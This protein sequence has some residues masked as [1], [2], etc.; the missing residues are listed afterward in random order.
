MLRGRLVMIGVGIVM[1]ASA[2][3]AAAATI[4]VNTTNDDQQQGDGRCSLRKAIAEVNSP[5]IS[6]TDCAPAAF[7]ANTIVLGGGS[8]LLGFSGASLNVASTADLR[9]LGVGEGSTF[10]D[11]RLLSNRAFTIAPGATVLLRNLTVANGHAPGGSSAAPGSGGAGQAG[12]NGGA[13]LNQGTLTV[14]NS[15]VTGSQGGTG[16]AGGSGPSPSSS[17]GGSGGAGGPGGS[18]GGIYNT[19]T[20]TLIGSTIADDDAGS[21]GAGGQGGQGTNGGVGGNGGAA[22]DGGGV[23]NA[24]G[25]LTVIDST[26]RSNGAG[27]GGAGGN[28]GSG[29]SGS[30]GAGGAGAGGAG[31]GGLATDGGALSVTNSTFASDTAGS[32]GAGGNGGAGSTTGGPGGAGGGAGS[33]GAVSASSPSSATLLQVTAAANDPGTPGAGGSAGTGASA[34]ASGGAGSGGAVFD[35]GSG[36]TLENSL[37]ALNAGGNCSGSVLDGGHD[38]SYGDSSCPATF[39]TGNPNLGPLQNNGGPAATISLQAGSA[40]I[41]QIPATNANCPSTD[42]R[43]VARPS[44]PKCDIGAYEVA[45]PVARTGAVTKINKTYATLNGVA[46]PNAGT[47]TVEFQYG[48]TPKLGSKSPTEQ[49]SGVVPAPISI[50]V[51]LLKPKRTYFYRLVV[52]AMDGT[53]YGVVGKFT[54]S[55]APVISGLSITPRSFRDGSGATISYLDSLAGKTTFIVLRCTKQSRGKCTRTRRA[56]SFSH[57]DRKGRNRVR[58]TGRV[59]RGALAAGAYVLDAT[60][61]AP[62]VGATVATRF[63][64]LG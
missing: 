64:I 40:A 31:G 5:G 8:Y 37:L 52:L 36:I 61:R 28:G 13:I 34:G 33:G 26:L 18:G 39:A 32:G 1:L 35:Q 55:P 42:E 27:N 41:D 38:L 11:A 19:G 56:G 9:I 59:G 10:I 25:S 62:Q 6:Q 24:G 12:A 16:G 4:V 17:S 29:T 45:P 51:L 50:R 22:G 21:G 48:L 63:T 44:G 47:A 30:G 57:A 46:T 7:G 15:A 23:S 2:A 3:P 54:T 60:P 14:E 58:F 20:L 49:V 43:G 53:S